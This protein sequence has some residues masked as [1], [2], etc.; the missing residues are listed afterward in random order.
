MLS[1]EFIFFVLLHIYRYYFIAV[2]GG[3]KFIWL[4]FEFSYGLKTDVY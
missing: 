2:S 1:A 3:F 4:K